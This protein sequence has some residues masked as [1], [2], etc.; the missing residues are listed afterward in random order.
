LLA[1][2]FL[3]CDDESTHQ[4]IADVTGLADGSAARG[5]FNQTVVC[6]FVATSFFDSLRSCA[7]FFP[8]KR[9]CSD[10]IFA[11]KSI[12]GKSLPAS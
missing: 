7:K 4:S 10:R 12:V 9:N 1:E 5:L 6:E 3:E 11:I 2:I 8:I